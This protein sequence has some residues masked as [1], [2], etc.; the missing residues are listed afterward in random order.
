MWLSRAEIWDIF[1]SFGSLCSTFQAVSEESADAESV[2]GEQLDRERDGNTVA[3]QQGVP[4]VSLSLCSPPF[5]VRCVGHS[6]S[7]DGL[8]S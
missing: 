7:V 4:A 8:S 5:T 6:S 3:R 2:T 1:G